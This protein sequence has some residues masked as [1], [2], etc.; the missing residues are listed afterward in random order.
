M[1]PSNVALA[2]HS[3]RPYVEVMHEGRR[4][5]VAEAR[6]A[7]LFGEDARV[8]RRY[9][10]DEL[11][12]RRSRRP[13]EIMPEPEESGN[14]WRIVA[15]DFVSADDGTGIV[16]MAPAFGA[17]D[18]AAGQRHGL[19][20]LQPVDAQGRFPESLPR[21]GGKFVKDADAELVEYLREQGVLWKAQR[22][23]HSYPH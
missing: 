17:D 15:E 11:L 5:V 4:L 7:A 8:V 9:G 19:A 20:F 21:G 2:V 3:E 13:F 22:F 16:H 6:V 14:A 18:Y 1:I 10:A 12:G 23:V